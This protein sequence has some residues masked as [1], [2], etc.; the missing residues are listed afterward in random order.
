MKLFYFQSEMIGQ[1]FFTLYITNRSLSIICQLLTKSNKKIIRSIQLKMK[2]KYI[3]QLKTF[4]LQEFNQK[5]NKIKRNSK[6]IS[7]N[8]NKTVI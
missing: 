6:A 7:L 2:N 4:K 8:L 5:L 1:L 3:V